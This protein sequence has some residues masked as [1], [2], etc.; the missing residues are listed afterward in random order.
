MTVVVPELTKPVEAAPV[1]P[2]EAE[3]SE[4]ISNAGYP[5]FA[6]WILVM[7]FIAF[8]IW[9]VYSAGIRLADP[10]SA[11]RWALGISL[12]GLMAYNYLAFGLFGIFS[13]L[14]ST[15]FSGLMMFVFLGE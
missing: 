6:A 13:W 7:L 1:A 9:V 10:R 2:V 15:G 12:G 5:R 3:I 11:L 4:Y 8:S 14:S